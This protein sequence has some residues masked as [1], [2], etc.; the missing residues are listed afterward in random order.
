MTVRRGRA[1]RSPGRPGPQQLG[2]A[3]PSKP[4]QMST[5]SRNQHTLFRVSSTFSVHFERLLLTYV[6][7][8]STGAGSEEASSEISNPSTYA[9]ELKESSDEIESIKRELELQEEDIDENLQH[10]EASQAQLKAM[11]Q[12]LRKDLASCRSETWKLQQCTELDGYKDMLLSRIDP[13]A[14]AG[15]ESADHLSETELEELNDEADT[16]LALL[17]AKLGSVRGEMEELDE[18]RK[19]LSK[20]LEEFSELQFSDSEDEGDDLRALRVGNVLQRA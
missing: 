5:G 12:D 17:M 19:L 4:F 6:R 11:I 14:G 16:Q 1:G 8:L 7:L 15:Q 10:S 3:R 13:S 18:K 2:P 20:E 9:W